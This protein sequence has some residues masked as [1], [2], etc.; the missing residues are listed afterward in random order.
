MRIKARRNGNSRV[1]QFILPAAMSRAI[2]GEHH[3][4][5]V[6]FVEGGIMM[7]YVG[8]AEDPANGRVHVV[9]TPKWAKQ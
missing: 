6:E 1:L 7:T 8:P 9:E 5:D 2:P 3:F 4:F